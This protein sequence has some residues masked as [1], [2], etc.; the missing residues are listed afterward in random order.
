MI[1]E[2]RPVRVD[3]PQIRPENEDLL[4]YRVEQLAQFAFLSPDRLLGLLP[5][6]SVDAGAVP[7]HDGARLVAERKGAGHEPAILPVRPAHAYLVLV[8]LSGREVRDP[9]LLEPY[10]V[11]GMHGGEPA[12]VPDVSRP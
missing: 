10:D 3:R 8:W 9:F 4:R 7:A 12:P 5:V 2:E 11:V 6:L 1:S